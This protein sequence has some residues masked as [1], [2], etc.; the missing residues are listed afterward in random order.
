[1]THRPTS[2]HGDQTL[3]LLTDP[4]RRLSHL[5]EQAGAD[6]VETRLALKETTC[7]RGR[8]A[9]RIF[10]DETRIVRAGAMP[11][12]VRRTLLGEG[13]VQGLDGEAHRA[14][15]G[16]FMSLMSPAR[17]ARLGELFEA[18]WRRAAVEWAGEDDI[19]L[20]DAL[21]PV[22]TR[23][24]C[25]WAGV[26]LEPHEEA[27]RVRHLRA[28]FDAAGSRGPRHLWSRHARRRVDAWLGSIIEDIRA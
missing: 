3:A 17:V 26:P 14:R 7:L 18:E 20:Y 27:K 4:Y 19:V 25:A 6:V 10:Y 11:A 8:E 1:M 5:F 23:A 21:Q 2:R 9:A 13:G 12:P 15:K 22:L 16:V 28:L 24:V